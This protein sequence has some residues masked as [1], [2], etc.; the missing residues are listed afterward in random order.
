MGNNGNIS[1]IQFDISWHFKEMSQLVHNHYETPQNVNTP[2]KTYKFISLIYRNKSN[3]SKH[4]VIQTVSFIISWKKWKYYPWHTRVILLR[5]A[6]RIRQRVHQGNDTVRKRHSS[7]S[8]ENK[9]ALTKTIPRVK[10]WQP[11]I[12]TS[13]LLSKSIWNHSAGK[14]TSLFSALLMCIS[15]T[16]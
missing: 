1:T 3:N 8:R 10:C 12:V 2:K 6:I 5:K 7:F 11:S 15:H 13:P 14:Q 4:L 16:L 9:Q